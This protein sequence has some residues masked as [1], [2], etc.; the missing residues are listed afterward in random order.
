MSPA[1]SHYAWVVASVTFLVLLVGAGIR[2]TPGVLIVPLQQAFGWSPATISGAIAINIL[3]YGLTGPFAVAVIERFGL[4]RT[5]TSSLLVLAFGT[6]V[7]SF[8]RQP[9]Q[10]FLVWGVL[11]GLGTG[12]VALVL[13]ATV[14]NRWFGRHRGLVLGVLT[15]SSATGQLIFLPV[16]AA[17][18]VDHGWRA[19]IY[20]V[21]LAALVLAPLAALALR[22]R[23]GDLGL[24]RFGETHLDANRASA[25]NPIGRALDGLK[26]GMRSP[27]FWLLAGSF[28]VCGA[29]TNGLIGTHLISACID[30]GIPE[31]KAA[32]LLA[33]MGLLDLAGTTAS[34]W[35]TDRVDSRY[36]LFW[37]YGLRGLSLV[38]L[39]YAF[40]LSFYGLSLFAV[41]YGLDWIATVPPTVRLAGEAFGEDNAALMFGWIAVAHQAGAAS[42]AW[43]AG[44]VR[45]STGSYL[46]AFVSAGLLC[47]V[48]AVMVLVIGRPHRSAPAIA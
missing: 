29:S 19:A 8:M 43:L 25:A 22:D 28:F 21:S 5:V 35:L 4:R 20:T 6:A 33:A 27:S 39:P 38:F 11:V 10:L 32:G 36:L 15:A 24:P 7:T 46:G 26:T 42:A 12:M 2:A 31:V 18:V 13:G 30:H 44:L 48:A 47:M 37:Y 14:A 40:D 3:L 45:T 41:F 23:P 1:R 9:W 16:L 34:G 17:L